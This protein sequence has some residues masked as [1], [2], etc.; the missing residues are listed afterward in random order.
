MQ[1]TSVV[2]TSPDSTEAID[3]AG[4]LLAPEPKPLPKEKTHQ[5][6][7]ITTN[8]GHGQSKARRKMANESRRRNRR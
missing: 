3:L 4:A 6:A 2:T 8:K 7:G 5:R 1:D